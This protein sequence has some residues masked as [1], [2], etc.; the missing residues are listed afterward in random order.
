MSD[1][2]KQGMG[3]EYDNLARSEIG[4][5]QISVPKNFTRESHSLTWAV[6]DEL[7]QGAAST[8]V[9]ACVVTEQS[10]KD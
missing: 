6:I 1:T 9:R 5:L 10:E 8:A 3:H 2:S 4:D 7:T